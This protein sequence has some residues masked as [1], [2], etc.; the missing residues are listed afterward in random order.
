LTGNSEFTGLLPDLFPALPLPL[1]WYLSR[2]ALISWITLAA[3]SLLSAKSL[4]GMAATSAV[5]VTCS[6]LSMLCL[7]ALAVIAGWQGR[8]SPSVRWL[9]DPAFF[10]DGWAL[11]VTHA[12]ATLPV[13]MTAFV[14]LLVLHWY[15]YSCCH[16]SLVAFVK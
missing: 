7:L 12:L 16:Y 3:A 14:S 6:V 9:P 2:S 8:L 10:G 4:H 1:P 13:V 15:V 11:V 5:S